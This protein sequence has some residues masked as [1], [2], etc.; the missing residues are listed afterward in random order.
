MIFSYRF[1]ALQQEK[2]RRQLFTLPVTPV[3]TTCSGQERVSTANI[4]ATQA[5]SQP[6]LTI[7]LNKIVF[8][9]G[10]FASSV[11]NYFMSS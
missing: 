11:F 9:W 3:E 6:T 8:H 1:A 2:K 10:F 4:V 5:L 7:P